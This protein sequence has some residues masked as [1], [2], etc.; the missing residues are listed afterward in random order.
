MQLHYNKKMLDDRRHFSLV[1]YRINPAITMKGDLG[2]I[3]FILF[4]DILQ[5]KSLHQ[6]MR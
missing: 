1:Y 2:G 3:I 5:F 4:A 6:A